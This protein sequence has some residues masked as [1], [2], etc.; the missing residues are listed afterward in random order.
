MKDSGIEADKRGEVLLL[1]AEYEGC[2][3]GYRNINIM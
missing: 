1:E 2:D 3:G